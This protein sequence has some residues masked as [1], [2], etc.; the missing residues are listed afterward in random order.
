MNK[1]SLSGPR[2]IR[3]Q[4]RK[5]LND[6]K[7]IKPYKNYEQNLIRSLGKMSKLLKLTWVLKSNEF[8]QKM[9]S[10]K[11]MYIYLF[12]LLYKNK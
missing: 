10:N 12:I 8:K 2:L 1:I 5:K 6:H 11:G 9:E 7:I 4:G 3:C